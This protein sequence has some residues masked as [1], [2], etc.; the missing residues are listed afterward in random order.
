M[1]EMKFITSKNFFID[2]LWTIP[3]QKQILKFQE[4]KAL[5]LTKI[6][7]KLTMFTVN[8]SI[9]SDEECSIS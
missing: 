6:L 1:I 3:K 4:L 7:Y 2:N 8:T 5:S 9:K